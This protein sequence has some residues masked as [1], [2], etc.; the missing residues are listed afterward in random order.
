MV[1]HVMMCIGVFISTVELVLIG[2]HWH[3]MLGRELQV[4]GVCVAKAIHKA[5]WNVAFSH[6]QTA[7]VVTKGGRFDV[8]EDRLINCHLVI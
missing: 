6:A 1:G 3:R 4:L 5:S 2:H 8:M 7:E